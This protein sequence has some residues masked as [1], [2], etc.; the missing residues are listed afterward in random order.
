MLIVFP[1]EKSVTA[2]PETCHDNRVATT[3]KSKGKARR[4]QALAVVSNGAESYCE[5]HTPEHWKAFIRKAK[6][7]GTW[8]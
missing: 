2:R 8:E 4:C 5:S 3:G 6:R 7:E 1:M